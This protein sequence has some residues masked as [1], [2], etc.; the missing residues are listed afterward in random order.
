M[1][2]E[3]RLT[4]IAEG[5][6]LCAMTSCVHRV[7]T[8]SSNVSRFR[9]RTTLAEGQGLGSRAP[10]ARGRPPCSDVPCA[11]HPSQKFAGLALGPRN[12]SSKSLDSNSTFICRCEDL[13]CEGLAMLLEQARMNRRH[14]GAQRDVHRPEFAAVIP[15][16][17]ADFS[18]LG[19]LTHDA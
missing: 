19:F 12:R 4:L 6:L 16:G 8:Q 13:G 15:E 18:L 14:P 7:P 1:D 5:R 17:P 10:A 3:N 9:W 11:G 2:S